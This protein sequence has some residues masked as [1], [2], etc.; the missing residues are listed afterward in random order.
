MRGRRSSVARRWLRVRRSSVA[1]KRRSS[2]AR[3]RRSSVARRRLRTSIVGCAYRRFSLARAQAGLSATAP[4]RS[5]MPADRPPRSQ[6]VTH[7]VR[8]RSAPCGTARP[9]RRHDSDV[10]RSAIEGRATPSR[11]SVAERRF[12]GR[13]GS[14]PG[15]RPFTSFSAATRELPVTTPPSWEGATPSQAIVRSAN[16]FRPQPSVRSFGE[17]AGGGRRFVVR[18]N[19]RPRGRRFVLRTN[20]R[21]EKVRCAN[22]RG[23]R[24]FLG[25]NELAGEEVRCANER[26]GGGGSSFGERTNGRGRRFVLRT[27][28]RAGE[29]VRSANERGRRFVLR[30][31]ERTREKVRSANE[32]AGGEEGSFGERTGE[33][34][35]S[36]NERTGWE[37]V[38]SASELA[39]KKVRSANLSAVRGEPFVRPTTGRDGLAGTEGV[40]AAVRPFRLRVLTPRCARAK[41]SMWESATAC[42]RSPR[43]ASR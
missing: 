7:C 38:R 37:E 33:E 25:T 32:R 18:T 1:R 42:V 3:K 17:R 30:T 15:S 34:V 39:G 5:A 35:R 12:A 29:K 11:A 36:A 16:Q 4:L 21:G 26:T 14:R 13:D 27:N 31:N 40:G 10:M 41:S 43:S 20:R 2:V 6:L 22:E 24:F 19:E 8:N 23:R 28:E 9:W